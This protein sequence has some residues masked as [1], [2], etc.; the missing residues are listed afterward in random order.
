MEGISGQDLIYI[1]ITGL[2]YPEF[3][4]FFIKGCFDNTQKFYLK[5]VF[6]A[7]REPW[8][9]SLHMQTCHIGLIMHLQSLSHVAA[10][11]QNNTYED[12]SCNHLRVTLLSSFET[13]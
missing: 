1:T 3:L 6:H 7:R 2:N 4:Y 11:L 13:C 12:C 10:G 5:P 8:T 9:I